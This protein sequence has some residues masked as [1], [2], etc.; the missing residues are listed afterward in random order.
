MADEEEK[1]EEPELEQQ[2]N[3][4]MQNEDENEAGGDDWG[5]D[6]DG[7]GEGWDEWDDDEDEVDPVVA[8]ALAAA[9]KKR[10]LEAKITEVRIAYRPPG[11][12]EGMVARIIGDFT[13]WVPFT[14]QMHPMNEILKDPTLKDEF[15]VIV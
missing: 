15:F 11:F 6:G 7:D 8:E 1:K 3:D 12:R 4:E 14:M 2:D 13:D 5:E 10:E 9:A